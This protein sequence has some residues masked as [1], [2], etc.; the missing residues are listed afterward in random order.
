MSYSGL[1]LLHRLCASSDQCLGAV[2]V[3][4]RMGSWYLDLDTGEALP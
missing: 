4:R 2:E 3:A 1:P